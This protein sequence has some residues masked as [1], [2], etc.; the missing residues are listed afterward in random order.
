M[1]KSL[2]LKSELSSSYKNHTTLKGLAGISPGGAITF[3]SQLY[4]SHISDREISTRSGFLTLP[5][6]RGDSVMADKG[7]TVE[8]L[9]PLWVSLNVPPFLGSKGQMS[10]EEVVE[11]QS[12]ASL[13]IPVERGINKMK[14]FHIWGL[15][16]RHGTPEHKITKTRNT[17]KIK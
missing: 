6:D 8:D 5:F 14:N 13:R 7:F 12:I 4:T 17:W 3:I 9:L 16:L 1:P 10:P 15:V 11:T 2:R